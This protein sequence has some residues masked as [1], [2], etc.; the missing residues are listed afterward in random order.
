MAAKKTILD[1]FNKKTI[2]KPESEPTD[3]EN[4]SGL[5]SRYRFGERSFWENRGW[6]ENAQEK[7]SE[8]TSQTEADG[9]GKKRKYSFVNLWKTNHLWLV[10]NEKNEMLCKYCIE[11]GK[12]NSF[13]QGN[14]NYRTS[15]LDRHCEL[16]GHKL[17]TFYFNPICIF[18]CIYLI[19]SCFHFE[20]SWK[21]NIIIWIKEGLK[22]FF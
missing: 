13:T 15:I 7:S 8:R 5:D 12:S 4:D 17:F 14:T 11:T 20:C 16:Q 9:S 22:S 21:L 2:D 6:R 18:K 19:P 1:F 3:L 10:L